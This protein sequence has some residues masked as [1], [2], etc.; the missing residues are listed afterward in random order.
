VDGK[1]MT[2]RSTRL[3]GA[4]VDYAY[5][6]RLPRWGRHHGASPSSRSS[7]LAELHL[8]LVDV[9][10]V[11]LLPRGSFDVL[12]GTGGGPL[13][14]PVGNPATSRSWKGNLGGAPAERASLV[15]A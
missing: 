4:G 2:E 13:G 1:S 7:G 12:H 9:C 3:A 6:R 5:E 11:A 14:D 15:G 8:F 10:V